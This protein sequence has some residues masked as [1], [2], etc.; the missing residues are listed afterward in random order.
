MSQKKK[1]KTAI[2]HLETII[3][4]DPN[5]AIAH[6]SLGSALGGQG[7]LKQ[8]IAHFNTAIKINPR[9]AEAHQ[10]L[11]TALSILGQPDKSVD[12]FKIAKE[13]AVNE[14]LKQ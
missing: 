11:S 7:N 6:N 14:K 8:A 3:K 12:H 10:N 2:D 13:L 4:M 9:Y 5:N 1:F